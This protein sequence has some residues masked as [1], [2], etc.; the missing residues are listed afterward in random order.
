MNNFNQ[1]IFVF[2]L[3]IYGVMSSNAVAL[4]VSSQELNALSTNLEKFENFLESLVTAESEGEEVWVD[5]GE[6]ATPFLIFLLGDN[7]SQTDASEVF[8]LQL[9]KGLLRARSK[10]LLVNGRDREGR[11]PLMLA[12]R[13]AKYKKLFLYLFT[14]RTE[15]SLTETDSNGNTVIHLSAAAGFD[16]AVF[17][18]L[19]SSEGNTYA[20]VQNSL[21]QTPLMLAVMAGSLEAVVYLSQYGVDTINASD[22]SGHTALDLAMEQQNQQLID[23]LQQNGAEPGCI[24][25]ASAHFEVGPVNMETSPPPIMSL[26][27]TVSPP[28]MMPRFSFSSPPPRPGVSSPA[29]RRTSRGPDQARGIGFS[30]RVLF[31]GD[32]S[33]SN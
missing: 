8:R 6:R 22:I 12:A 3:G 33:T 14:R 10:L 2:V 25:G 23:L 31:R 11:T 4:K 30:P 19:T 7:Y 17:N 20:N 24:L 27:S 32:D 28:P 29:V 21:G 1:L 16:D 15:Q 13:N 5:E 9:I 18:I 26:P